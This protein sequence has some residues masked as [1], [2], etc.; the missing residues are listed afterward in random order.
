MTFEWPGWRWQRPPVG[1][2]AVGRPPLS[3]DGRQL[4][5]GAK[6]ARE[7]CESTKI[8]QPSKYETMPLLDC[9]VSRYC[10]S[11]REAGGP[12]DLIG[13]QTTG[14][15]AAGQRPGSALRRRPRDLPPQSVSAE[16]SRRSHDGPSSPSDTRRPQSRLAKH[17]ERCGPKWPGI[18]AYTVSRIQQSECHQCRF[19]ALRP[20]SRR[21][22]LTRRK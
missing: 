17:N 14:W 11:L 3:N 20:P 19:A 2:N 5:I 16:P 8:R 9:L 15:R 18:T 4:P 21:P 12:R 13:R 10:S 7:I 22:A 6:S 1:A